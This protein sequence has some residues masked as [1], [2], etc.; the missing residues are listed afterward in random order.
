M[1]FDVPGYTI[2]RKI[3]YG[4]SAT[5]Y[6]AVQ[7]NLNRRVALKVLHR[8]ITADPN[9]DQ[10][11][12]RE[13]RII[14]QL[15]HTN[16]VPVYDI[17]KYESIYYMALE[18]LPGG[19]LK[20]RT[21]TMTLM[22]LVKNISCICRAL[23]YAHDKGYVHR[24]IKAENILFRGDAAVLTDFGIAR[25]TESLTNMT[26]DGTLL[27]TPSYMSPEQLEGKPLDGRTDLYSMG[28]L[29]F[30][31]LSGH[32]PFRGDSMVSIG[33]KHVSSAVP[34]LPPATALFQTLIDSLLA[35]NPK[36]RPADAA[37]VIEQLERLQKKIT[38][39]TNT[40]LS[41]LWSEIPP[42]ELPLATRPF[43]TRPFGTRLKTPVRTK[44][45]IVAASL[46]L[47]LL[48]GLGFF[49]FIATDSKITPPSVETSERLSA[50]SVQLQRAQD[51]MDKG[52]VI[53]PENDNA[54]SVYRKVLNKAPD[55]A[56]ALTGVQT[57]Q[58]H[59]VEQIENSISSQGFDQAE[60]ELLTAAQ[61]WPHS[62]TVSKLQL[63]L[64]G[65]KKAKRQLKN[66]TD[67]AAYLRLA[68]TAIANQQWTQPKQA[69]AFWYYQQALKL[70]S[71]NQLA[72]AGTDSVTE[73]ILMQARQ[74]L[75]ENSFQEAEQLIDKAISINSRHAGI[76]LIKKRLRTEK[77][78]YKEK[79]QQQKLQAIAL[80]NERALNTEIT[81]ID[82]Q[83]ENWIEDEKDYPLALS[84]ADLINNKLQ[85]L[86]IKSP[87]NRQL[88][89]L[90][91]QIERHL[92]TLDLKRS[93]AEKEIETLDADRFRF[94]NF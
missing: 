3:G 13:G 77:N 64:D 27:G 43:A 75:S 30:K 65:P 76:K 9:F 31:L 66:Q 39:P 8:F 21:Q 19:D 49:S 23:Q 89:K 83:V 46:V 88:L 94:G 37:Q 81:D 57:V 60:A 55:N 10:R 45:A 47:A 40:L 63:E 50:L 51:L 22:Q 67:V 29:L 18:Y 70:D 69:N 71:D 12:Q 73:H 1:D 85:A 92:E 36:Q 7:E 28:I 90:S 56:I 33:L 62:K 91:S 59:I 93:Q 38:I 82:R 32:L 79:L 87:D 26:V 2:I 14:A 11:F 72:K 61:L 16:I 52:Q 48:F 84:E 4:G 34:S 80:Q 17:G 15:N 24:D 44:N 42:E 78:D 5:V 68:N 25:P 53:T 6:L 20:E 86:L 74:K 35:K 54:L 41:S 58:R